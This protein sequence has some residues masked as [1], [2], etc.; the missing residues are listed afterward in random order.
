MKVLLDAIEKSIERER[1]VTSDTFASVR[2]EIADAVEDQNKIEEKVDE[3]Q[4]E[5]NQLRL[6]IEEKFGQLERAQFEAERRVQTDNERQRVSRNR[7]IIGTVIATGVSVI[8]LI[9]DLL[10]G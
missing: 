5:I 8:G 1:Q 6:D 2:R 10:K 7:W 3:Q 9:L 4:T